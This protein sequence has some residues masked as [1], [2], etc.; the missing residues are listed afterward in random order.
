VAVRHAWEKIPVSVEI[1]KEDPLADGG[2]VV[3]E[4]TR[5][6]RSTRNAFITRIVGGPFDGDRWRSATRD[7]ALREHAHTIEIFGEG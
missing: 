7:E 2:K 3:T 1:V 4:E 6:E 5:D